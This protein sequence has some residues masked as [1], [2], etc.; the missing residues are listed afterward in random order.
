MKI[1]KYQHNIGNVKKGTT[2][3]F[4]VKLY[5]IGN[6]PLII[7]NVESECGCTVTSL[8]NRQI[9][10]NM[11]EELKIVYLADSVYPDNSTFHKSIIIKSNSEK[12]I[13]EISFT[14]KIVN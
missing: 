9:Q 8:K 3:E 14:G 5:N 7:N 4:F 12:I 11:F 10:P 2:K 13:E 6:S 1:E